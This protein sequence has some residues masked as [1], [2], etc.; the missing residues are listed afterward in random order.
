M[1]KKNSLPSLFPTLV[2]R[3]DS[4]LLG[5]FWD[6]A[7]YILDLIWISPYHFK[8]NLKLSIPCSHQIWEHWKLWG[9]PQCVEKNHWV[10][11]SKKKD[12]K[13]GDGSSKKTIKC[14]SVDGF[15]FYEEH[16]FCYPHKHVFQHPVHNKRDDYIYEQLIMD[17]LFFLKNTERQ[18][19]HKNA[20]LS[21]IQLNF[22]DLNYIES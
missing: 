3:K 10:L 17:I 16:L 22:D 4:F 8:F 15:K 12:K 5:L 21:W 1:Y 20:E 2:P 19:H 9:A 6:Q 13:W 14:V 18:Y 11:N 7:N